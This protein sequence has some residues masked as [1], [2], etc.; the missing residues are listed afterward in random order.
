[1][2][3]GMMTL[4][5]AMLAL[6]VLLRL[7]TWMFGGG[8]GGGGAG[9]AA[10]S[11]AANGAIMARG[12]RSSNASQHAQ[13]LS[14][15]LGPTPPAG[16]PGVP[17]GPMPGGM[18]S[19][20]SAGAMPGPATSTA[21]STARRRGLERRRNCHRHRGRRGG[22]RRGGRAGG[23]GRGRRGDGCR[24]CSPTGRHRR[25]RHRGH[26]GPCWAGG[27]LDMSEHSIRSTTGSAVESSS[28]CVGSSTGRILGFTARRFDDSDERA[29]K[30]I[31]SPTNRAFRKGQELF[32]AW[33]A[34]RLL[35]ERRDQ[36]ESLVVCEG[37]ID[38][39]V[40]T[41]PSVGPPSPLAAR[42]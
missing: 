20:G 21:S 17:S 16:G 31:N 33:E 25:P 9:L 8:P 39:S 15:D 35:R 7:F 13:T 4:L 42:R 6:P 23:A 24:R 41:P 18:P 40:S 26:L 29:P 27:G 22:G 34:R 30:Y 10:A 11:L 12:L 32:G 37:P 1:M 38:A 2:V 28:Q 36:I 5:V 19:G 3:V 14:A